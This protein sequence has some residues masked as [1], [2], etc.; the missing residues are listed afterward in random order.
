MSEHGNIKFW[1]EIG[2]RNVLRVAA[3]Y[4]GFSWAVVHSG[5]VVGEALE[6]P[7]WIM[8]L[9]S[10][11]LIVGFPAV[12]AFAWVY[13]I[14]PE[15]LKRTV[16]V[17]KDAS[18]THRTAQRLNVVIIVLVA[19]LI[20]LYGAD[21]F[22]PRHEATEGTE[23]ATAEGATR[24]PAAE[25]VSIA[26]L[27]FLNLSGDPGQEFFSDGM[28]EEIT[29]ALAKVKGLRVVGRTSAF[30][31][32]GQNKDLHAIGQAL[33][34]GH[35][36]EGSVRKEGSQIRVTAQ[37]IRADD[38][39]HIW[40]ENYDRELKSVFA[41][42]DEISQAIAGAL[43]VPLGLKPGETLVANRAIDPNSYQQYLAAKAIVRGRGRT[44]NDMTEA[45]RL[46][47]QVVARDSQ[48]APAWSLL[49]QAYTFVPQEDIS[50]SSTQME[51]QR[52]LA[53]V[54]LPK[55]E[56]AARHA[57]ELDPSSADAHTALSQNSA[58]RGK[59]IEAEAEY[60]R[61]LALDPMN[62][63]ALH[64][65]GA[66]LAD[67]GKLKGALV[68]RRQLQSVEPL[69]P[70]FNGVTARILMAD[71]QYGA[72]LSI[73]TALPGDSKER[74]IILGQTYAEMGRYA[75]AADAILKAPAG[76][77]PPGD[78]EA[79]AGLLRK[80]PAKVTPQDLPA[81]SNRLGLFY[82]YVGA[83][84]RSADNFLA[85]QERVLDTGY[86]GVFDIAWGSWNA[87]AR[88]TVRF[89]EI[90]RKRGYVDYWR[91]RGW[92]D[93]CHPIGPD[94]FACE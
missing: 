30:E 60:M 80:A 28:T 46:L 86:L 76:V 74:A 13:E 10:A 17:E 78:A 91:A 89:K 42:Q 87:P 73:L 51:E 52:R 67:A 93:V 70:V 4:V 6:L 65:A 53:G 77:Y 45:V 35:L 40:T 90:L 16:E 48:Y 49:S 5:V 72:A 69:V 54:Y 11:L 8:R 22:L 9:I 66:Q 31:F 94:D 24:V 20:G 26:V 64:S 12:V 44:G 55:S 71:G 63:D 57:I 19:I 88:K 56:A 61:A 21:R 84:E 79:A 7:H 36:L 29:S 32:K 37:L 62:P 75:E 68:I 33:R 82:R 92:P 85:A 14:T 43:Q 15:G 47:E 34:A 38:G 27:P 25:G 83:S 58:R 50:F 23:H 81:F 59:P 41:I 18:L 2:R 3:V 1:Q 39:T